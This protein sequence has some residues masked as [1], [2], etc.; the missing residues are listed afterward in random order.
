M[1]TRT[2][3]CD[4]AAPVCVA[5]T[6]WLFAATHA[7]LVGSRLAFVY[8]RASEDGGNW[9]LQGLP[10]RAVA[11]RGLCP[12]RLCPVAREVSRLTNVHKS[13]EG[14]PSKV[15]ILVTAEPRLSN[16]CLA[17]TSCSVRQVLTSSRDFL[18][19]R[20][21]KLFPQRNPSRYGALPRTNVGH[22]VFC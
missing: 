1:Q 15:A 3:T 8:A 20:L 12:T 17:L 21:S 22:H 16:V 14:G 18:A 2:G 6:E 5:G 10:C 13:Q 4:I 7:R 9:H 11:T 19:A